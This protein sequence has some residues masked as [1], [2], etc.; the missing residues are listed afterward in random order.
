MSWN[1]KAELAKKAHEI[2]KEK[3]PNGYG[4]KQFINASKEVYGGYGKAV[5][6]PAHKP[7]KTREDANHMRNAMANID[8][9][10]PLSMTD[11]EVI[12]INGD[13][14]LDCPVFREGDCEEVGDFLELVAVDEEL[15]D[16]KKAEI[17]EM[18][19]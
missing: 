10:Y 4:K 1:P 16:E 18:Y 7:V 5:L 13:C 9:R 11:C 8:G 19:Q 17:L 2:A 15:T 14:G 6:S 12:G 3:H